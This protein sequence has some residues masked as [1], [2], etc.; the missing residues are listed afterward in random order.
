MKKVYISNPHVYSSAGNSIE[1]VW[2]SVLNCD[3][4][5][6]Q[7]EN[8]NQEQSLYVGRINIPG[9]KNQE[10]FERK[11]FII[12]SLCNEIK[13]LVEAAKKEYSPKR[14][15]VF[16]GTSDHGSDYS[17]EKNK[18]SSFHLN[19]NYLSNHV[20]KYFDLSGPCTTCISSCTSS[21]YAIIKA[22]EF[23]EAG[24]I[25]FAIVGGLELLSPY[26]LG[27][28]LS[29]ENVSTKYS[30]P[31]SKNRDG[32]T[33][34]ECASV[35]CLCKESFKKFSDSYTK[36]IFIAGYGDSCDAY[37]ITAPSPDA[38]GA[39]SAINAALKSADLESEMIGY[40]NL[41]GTGTIGNDK[42]ECLAM[43]K[44]FGENTVPA[45]TT[46]PVTGHTMGASSSLEVA[47]CY[48]ILQHADSSTK[49]ALPP[50]KWDGEYDDNLCRVNFVSEKK[51]FRDWEKPLKY[52]MS[53]SFAFGG[54]NVA[55]ITGR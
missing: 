44:V 39:V 46:K 34:S 20:Q 12:D 16:F 2:N 42:M 14:I 35:F 30:N 55:I 51:Y 19:T 48:S 40:V 53:L 45:S 7:K 11:Y 22:S 25:D 54:S 6:F 1:S 18:D 15:G 21:G 43:K 8:F 27:G 32:I 17:K 47:I 9:L 23:I 24:F 4:S 49:Y 37:H 31:F 5:G 26:T 36:D 29:L 52:C 3:T 13:D 28:F 38:E 41:H 50:Q 10:G 33:M